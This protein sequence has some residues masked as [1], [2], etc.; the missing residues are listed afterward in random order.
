MFTEDHMCL[1]VDVQRAVHCLPPDQRDSVLLVL[2]EELTEDEAAEMLGVSRR[3]IQ[4]RVWRAAKA[5]RY[6]LLP[7]S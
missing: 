3:M 1:R 6:R 4:R 5:L 2:M 7:Y